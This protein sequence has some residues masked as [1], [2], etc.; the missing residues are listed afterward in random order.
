M[1][2]TFYINTTNLSKCRTEKLRKAL[3]VF[4]VHFL[5]I[6]SCLNANAQALINNLDYNNLHNWDF[7][8]Y[9]FYVERNDTTQNRNNFHVFFS[10]RYY[11]ML[12]NWGDRDKPETF[13]ITSSLIIPKDSIQFSF[14]CNSL[15]IDSLLLKINLYKNNEEFLDKIAYPLNMNGVNKISF[16]NTEAAVMEVNIQ[17]KSIQQYDSISLEIIDFKV[18][19]TNKEPLTQIVENQNFHINNMDVI[20]LFDIDQFEDFKTKKIIGLGESIH[21]SRSIIEKTIGITEKLCEDNNLKLVCFEFGI[22]MVMNWDLYIQGILPESYRQKIEDEV[23][24]SFGEPEIIIEFLSKLRTINKKRKT[25]EKIHV[26][27]LDIRQ[28]DFYVFEYLRAYKNMSRRKDFLNDVFLKIDTLNYNQLG[29][30]FT[31]IVIGKGVTN[32]GRQKIPESKRYTSLIPVMENFKSLEILMGENNYRY[33]TEGFLLNIPTDR[34]KSSDSDIGSRRDYIMWQILQLAIACYAPKDKDRIVINS[35]SM[36]LSKS[37]NSYNLINKIKGLG[38][39]ITENYHDDYLAVSFQ[40]GTGK[41]KTFNSVTQKVGEANLQIPPKGSFEQ[42]AGQVCFNDFYCK[43]SDLGDFASFRS[44][45]SFA[46]KNNQFYPFSLRRFDGYVYINNSV[47]CSP[48]EWRLSE[49]IGREIDK[50]IYID[51]LEVENKPYTSLNYYI[52]FPDSTIKSHITIPKGFRWKNKFFTPLG[53]NDRHYIIKGFFKSEDQECIILINNTLLLN[54]TMY[55]RQ[56]NKKM[57]F[58]DRM[59]EEYARRG[60]M[61]HAEE[62]FIE[63]FSLKSSLEDDE[64]YQKDKYS[65]M[66]RY[67]RFRDESYAKEVFNADK[68]IEIPLRITIEDDINLKPLG[69]FKHGEAILLGK[70]NA[71]VRLNIFYTDEGYRQK[72]KYRKAIESLV[73]FE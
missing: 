27:G 1:F 43:Q 37:Y 67:L 22:D 7:I 61:A 6:Y 42:A 56:K 30:S 41:F 12:T 49:K 40:V 17:G 24:G 66:R 65:L 73:T 31:E 14:R 38:V 60:I 71:T 11:D 45:G 68:V 8:S 33:F 55:T 26:V 62:I 39:Y 32:S 72:E 23:T 63:S 59:E 70:K 51:S 9:P 34:D 48:L 28:N 36:H 13:E 21:G 69:D 54:S 2:K 18:N 15:K 64:E 5:L 44:I 20:P 57:S 25:D 19:T 35:H 3:K 50:N 16:R 10:K 53:N 46:K 29:P 52:Y 4:L 47:P 58:H